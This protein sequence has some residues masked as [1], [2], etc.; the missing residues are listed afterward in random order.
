[1]TPPESPA[2]PSEAAATTRAVDRRPGASVLLGVLAAATRALAGAPGDPDADDAALTAILGRTVVP[3]L[4]D[5]VALY[6]ADARGA[7]RLI[8]AAPADATP[9]RRLIE[10]V[11][12]HPEVVAVYVAA[13]DAGRP[14]ILGPAAEPDRSAGRSAAT[15]ALRQATGLVTEIVAPL[16]ADPR[17]EGLLVVGSTDPA[18]RYDDADRSATE[19]L[20]A[21]IGARRTATQQAVRVETLRQ[22]VDALALAGRELAHLLNNDLT[23]P[24]GV[25]ELL[26]DRNTLTPDLQ[27]M[28]QASAKDLAALEQ[29]V[30]AFHDLMREYPNS[31]GA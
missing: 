12:Q 1:M 11:E 14:S 18:R 5:V 3:T 7:V 19:V 29:H 4:G 22:Q 20:A 25:V 17:R 10:H 21:I 24:V 16:G 27:E 8:G 31:P 6:A 23:L 2:E 15:V 13:A 28:L 9:A 30:R 26:L